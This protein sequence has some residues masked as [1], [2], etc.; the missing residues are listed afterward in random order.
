[1]SFILFLLLKSL[2]S[3]CTTLFIRNSFLQVKRPRILRIFL[4]CRNRCSFR[5]FLVL[6][7]HLL[8]LTS[9]L[10]MSRCGHYLLSRCSRLNEH[11][12]T[13][14]RVSASLPPWCKSSMLLCR[15]WWTTLK[16]S[17][18]VTGSTDCRAGYHSAHS[19]LRFV[20]V[21]FTSS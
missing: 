15:R 7:V 6:L 2:L 16:T 13:P 18:A 5:L 14:W 3:L 8:P 10:P 12:G 17:L 11:S 1:M 21:A 20:S 9:L 19:F 4:L